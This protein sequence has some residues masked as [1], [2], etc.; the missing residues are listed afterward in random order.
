M[1]LACDVSRCVCGLIRYIAHRS[2]QCH[3]NE[4]ACCKFI[5]ITILS[6]VSDVSRNYTVFSSSDLEKKSESAKNP[7]KSAQVRNQ[8]R[9]SL[10][11]N[12]FQESF[13]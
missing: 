7:I 13:H 6:E 12:D 2:F 4:N 1:R 9:I 3:V 5:K 11:L 8:L 10:S